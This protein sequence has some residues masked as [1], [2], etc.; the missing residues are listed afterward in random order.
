MK[1]RRGTLDSKP[2]CKSTEETVRILSDS[3]SKNDCSTSTNTTTSLANQSESDDDMEEEQQRGRTVEDALS[4]VCASGFVKVDELQLVSLQHCNICREANVSWKLS[5]NDGTPARLLQLIQP[6]ASSR[7]SAGETDPPERVLLPVT[8][9]HL[10]WEPRSQ[11]CMQYCTKKT[12]K[13]QQ[14]Y[15]LCTF[16]TIHDIDTAV[17][18]SL[19]TQLLLFNLRGGDLYYDSSIISIVVRVV[20]LTFRYGHLFEAGRKSWRSAYPSAGEIWQLTAE[21]VSISSPTHGDI[22]VDTLRRLFG[23]WMV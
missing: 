5:V 6:G 18:Q 20:A 2:P 21:Q 14:R 11:L 19:N 8:I 12:R 7:K 3:S 23:P 13:P 16:N 1:R 15:A 22:I 9:R 17:H 4:F 10:R